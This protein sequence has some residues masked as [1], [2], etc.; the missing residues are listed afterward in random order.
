MAT[1]SVRLGRRRGGRR[2]TA[3]RDHTAVVMQSMRITASQAASERAT[4][5]LQGRAAGA[6]PLASAWRGAARSSR[7]SRGRGVLFVKYA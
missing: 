5:D 7:K 6:S 3:T 2:G 1:L 4:V